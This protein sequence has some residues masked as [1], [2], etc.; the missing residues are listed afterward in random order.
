MQVAIRTSTILASMLTAI[1]KAK[2]VFF[3]TKNLEIG[4]EEMPRDI[5][6]VSALLDLENKISVVH[7]T[8]M[9]RTVNL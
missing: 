6:S 5:E 9:V 8:G 1:A 4:L 3:N 2:L 7:T